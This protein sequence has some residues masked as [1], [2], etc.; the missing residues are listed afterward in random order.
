MAYF[1]GGFGNFGLGDYS[2]IDFLLFLPTVIITGINIVVDH[3]WRVLWSFLLYLVVPN[4]FGI[5]VAYWIYKIPSLVSHLPTVF[6]QPVIY[7]SFV[8]WIVGLSILLSDQFKKWLPILLQFLGALFFSVA[9]VGVAESNTHLTPINISPTI[10]NIV[11]FLGDSIFLITRIIGSLLIILLVGI[12]IARE[13]IKYKH[14]SQIIKIALSQE[15]PGLEQWRVQAQSTEDLTIFSFF[16]PKYVPT[17]NYLYV[18]NGEAF[19]VATLRNVTAIYI[20]TSDQHFSENG[21]LLLV[22]NTDI[23]SL[24]LKSGKKPS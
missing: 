13:S 7:I 24:E 15:L 23:Q 6:Y 8:I 4:I 12:A 20:N 1:A 9:A 16:R 17:N 18:P 22:S 2:V 5:L 14:L 19:L 10:M 21:R 3:F 11:L